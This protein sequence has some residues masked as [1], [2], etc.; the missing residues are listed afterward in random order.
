VIRIYQRCLVSDARFIPDGSANVFA[1]LGLES[2]AANLAKSEFAVEILR[3]I[4]E[5]YP[6]H[7]HVPK[8]TSR[9]CVD[10]ASPLLDMDR[11]VEAVR[12]GKRTG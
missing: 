12:S 3:F 1:D 6:R 5:I 9:Y 4:Q 10:K 7:L 2:S 8:A 11:P